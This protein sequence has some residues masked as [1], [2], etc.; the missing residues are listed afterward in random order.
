MSL[1][2]KFKVMVF[3]TLS[4][5]TAS[6]VGSVKLEVG[7]PAPTLKGQTDGA[8]WIELSKLYERGLVLVYFYPKADTPGCTAQACSLRDSYVELQ[9]SG[10]EILG[11][12]TDS[13]DDL[14]KFKSKH[15]LPFYLISDSEKAWAKAF[16]VP[17]TF[18]FTA[19]QAFLIEKS[20]IVW[21]DRSASTDKQA[22]DVL[23][24]LKNRKNNLL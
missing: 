7:S 21:M 19:R 8:D 15:R 1:L 17:T 4:F 16:G 22:E 18:G 9:K 2:K 13:V 12:S 11:V 6:A 10:V 20:K 14:K 23:L 24:F 3:T 5:Y